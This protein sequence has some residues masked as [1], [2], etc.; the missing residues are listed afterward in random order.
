M[1][2][3]KL[4]VIMFLT[5][6]PLGLWQGYVIQTIW[7]WHVMPVF[8]VA[9]ISIGH[10][11]GLSTIATM[12]TYRLPSTPASLDS[13]AQLSRLAAHFLVPLMCLIS[14]FIAGLFA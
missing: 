2:K 14:A 12:L 5:A 8:G 13:T 10:A 11:W 1:S 3:G 9:G 6:V 4:V 7:S